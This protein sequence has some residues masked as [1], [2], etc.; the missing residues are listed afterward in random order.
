[1][2][3]IHFGFTISCNSDDE[4]VAIDGKT[5]RGTTNASDKQG[6]KV[7]FAVTH[8]TRT[9]V[10][11]CSMS[12]PKS[13]EVS[14][15]R[16]LLQQTGLEK[17]KVTLDSLHCTPATTAQINQAGGVYLTQIKEN[18]EIL[19][20]QAQQLSQNALPLGTEFNKEKGHG[21]VTERDDFFL[22]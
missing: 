19:L 15:V 1:M 18:Q 7:V 16:R 4:W 14:V 5:L 10:A 9:N 13:G 20:K 12:G 2:I 21:R 11:Q 22:H 3:Q 6:E 8:K 17:A